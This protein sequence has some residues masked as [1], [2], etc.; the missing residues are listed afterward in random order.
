[1]GFPSNCFPLE[2]R[3]TFQLYATLRLFGVNLDE[4]EE[5]AGLAN[6]QHL[7]EL[8]VY[9]LNSVNLTRITECFPHLQ[10]L[11]LEAP[12]LT[13]GSLHSLKNLVWLELSTLNDVMG[14]NILLNRSFL[15]LESANTLTILRLL[16]RV[17]IDSYFFDL[18][19]FVNLNHICVFSSRINGVW[20]WIRFL[21]LRAD[22]VVFLET[23]YYVHPGNPGLPIFYSP[24]FS[25][26]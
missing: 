21:P 24:Y 23:A 12:P 11:S 17:G 4:R 7:V 2:F 26:I 15:P 14:E 16:E 25:N 8:S 10:R 3:H 13:R 20:K 19:T 22:N 1:M 18:T 6:C 5:W 9:P